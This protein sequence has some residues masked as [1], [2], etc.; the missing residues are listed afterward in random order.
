[1]LQTGPWARRARTLR[2]DWG[3][4]GPAATSALQVKPF[5][6][7]ALEP[8]PISHP[9]ELISTLA[10]GGQARAGIQLLVSTATESRC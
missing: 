3:V 4:Q 9:R 6:A 10:G 5:W 7:L 8:R 1:M 2:E